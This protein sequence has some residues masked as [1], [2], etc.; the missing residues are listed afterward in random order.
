QEED[1]QY[2]DDGNT[3]GLNIIRASPLIKDLIFVLKMHFLQNIDKISYF[4]SDALDL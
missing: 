1:E 2:V 4:E 3:L